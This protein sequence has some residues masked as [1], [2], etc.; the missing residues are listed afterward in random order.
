MQETTY[1]L[2]REKEVVQAMWIYPS[3]PKSKENLRPGDAVPGTELHTNS[4]DKPIAVPHHTAA[5]ERAQAEKN[6]Q[7]A[8]QRRKQLRSLI[9]CYFTGMLAAGIF[10]ATVQGRGLDFI[11]YYVSFVM[12]VRQSGDEM[13]IFSTEF[14]GSVLLMTLELLCGFCAFGVPILHSLI[15]LR[16]CGAGLFTAAL[17]AERRLRG[18]LINVML[19]WIPEVLLSAMLIVF[20]AL[21]RRSAGYLSAICFGNNQIAKNIVPKDLLW[22]YLVFCALSMIPC[23]L[24]AVLAHLFV[25]IL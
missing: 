19:F 3:Q 20:C 10:T 9:M 17:Y 25:P 8:V 24:A 12:K 22:R 21:A 16:G 11:R 23:G 2:I 15:L 4:T 18:L 6:S 1:L 7:K 5:K 14:L 13:L